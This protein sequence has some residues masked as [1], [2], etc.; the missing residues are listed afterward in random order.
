VVMD[1]TQHPPAT[2]RFTS[3]EVWQ[4]V[5][6]GLLHPDEPFEFIDGQ[7]R[8][9]SP[10]GPRHAGIIAQLGTVLVFAYDTAFQV[11]VQLPIGG[12]ADQI[13]EPDLAVI[14]APAAID[15]PHPRADETLVIIDVSDSSIAWDV[16]KGAIYASAGAPLYWRI[17]VAR[18]VV[19]VHQ[20]PR[21]DGTW[22]DMVEVAI[23]GE[24]TLPGVGAQLALA[25]IFDVGRR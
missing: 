12:I 17:E 2:R 22:S 15:A 16:R 1:A 3:D 24:L 18:Q 13:P 23:G 8:Y 4:M 5:E 6:I 19:V 20:G 14:H 7:L 25:R 10:Q 9:V 11:R 21:A